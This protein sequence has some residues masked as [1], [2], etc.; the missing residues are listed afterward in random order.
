M[1]IRNVFA[2][3]RC[4]KSRSILGCGL[5]V[6]LAFACT[7]CL[8]KIH[9][10]AYPGAFLPPDGVALIVVNE[11]ADAVPE[12]QYRRASIV[13]IDHCEAKES[14]FKPANWKAY[15]WGAKSV[16]VTPG[17]HTLTIQY[18]YK[19]QIMEIING[20]STYIRHAVWKATDITIDAVEGKV[21]TILVS[22]D[23]PDPKAMSYTHISATTSVEARAISGEE[24]LRA[25]SKSEEPG[26]FEEG[27][28]Y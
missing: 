6:L 3:F 2:K 20:E 27:C 8:S 26:E 10:R 13:K 28:E 14:I 24:I 15:Q 16:E 7:S 17:S 11:N 5:L 18:E 4:R 1:R 21:Y 19:T 12:N 22:L 9:V 25:R 23:D